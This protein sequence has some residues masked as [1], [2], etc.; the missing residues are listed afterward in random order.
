MANENRYQSEYII[1][2]LRE[3][4]RLLKENS[5]LKN[6]LVTVKNNATLKTANVLNAVLTWTDDS[7]C[8][9]F[10]DAFS[11]FGQGTKET[12]CTSSRSYYEQSSAPGAAITGTVSYQNEPTSQQSQY[13]NQLKAPVQNQTVKPQSPFRPQQQ[14]ASADPRNR[15][16]FQADSQFG[17]A[18]NTF[19]PISPARQEQTNLINTSTGYQT[20]ESF[21]QQQYYNTV[22]QLGHQ[23]VDDTDAIF[24]PQQQNLQPRAS[25][26]PT[27]LLSPRID[28][29][30][31]QRSPIAQGIP[32][33]EP[34]VPTMSRRQSPSGQRS[35][36]PQGVPSF[37]GNNTLN[38]QSY[39]REP[40]IRNDQ[41]IQIDQSS[42][43]PR[44]Q[45]TVP[46]P[47]ISAVNQNEEWNSLIYQ[48]PEMIS[49][50]QGM[51]AEQTGFSNQRSGSEGYGSHIVT[52]AA[53]SIRSD[54]RTRLGEPVAAST[55]IKGGRSTQYEYQDNTLQSMNSPQKTQ[56]PSPQTGV[57]VLHRPVD[58]V[59]GLKPAY[60]DQHRQRVLRIRPNKRIIGEVAFQLDRRILEY[61]FT[62]KYT[63]ES[64]DDK[65]RRFYGYTISNMGAMIRKEA[66]DRSGQFNP[67]KELEMRYRFDYVI[68]ALS[69]YGYILERHAI[70]SQDLVN[71][72]GLLS[73]P[74][75]R[76]TARDIGL[77]D[78]VI[79]RVLLSQMIKDDNLLQEAL[80]LLDCLCLL[81]HE[82]KRT[83]FLY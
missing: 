48:P 34:L 59:I 9:K 10:E 30:V 51:K 24:L 14:N 6:Y 40:A 23:S 83:I 69:K 20:A 60:T 21:P 57:S 77:D 7:L 70:L 32:V 49:N 79:L 12:C 19:R 39:N 54:G 26:M 45:I 13:I 41:Y 35:P 8:R 33:A 27:K 1:S 53:D 3:N 68:K 82:D 36:M 81:A 42:I 31:R 63:P 17:S 46:S 47:N 52:E 38:Q 72:Y 75:D 74:P 62:W 50:Y 80:I 66:T 58:Q 55:P 37:G 16:Q 76:K 18:E 71:R 5:F 64:S 2:L 25:S 44:V 43:N 22:N 29:N 4:D 11:R 56:K 65:R 61:V 73:G 15:P 28:P 67:K 78:P